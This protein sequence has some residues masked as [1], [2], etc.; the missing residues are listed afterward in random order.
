M[1]MNIYESAEDYL[2]RILM[3]KNE[4]G[5]VR[6]IDIANS[7]GYSRPSISRAIKN[8]R[9]N[10]YIT[11]STAGYIDLTKKGYDIANKILERHHIISEVLVFLGVSKEQALDDACK[12][13]HDLSDETFNAI[14]EQYK[15]IK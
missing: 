4:I 1:A 15:K 7:F 13:E 11:V 14:K 6:S 10:D 8:L 9:E 2:E 3:L 5:T 12:I